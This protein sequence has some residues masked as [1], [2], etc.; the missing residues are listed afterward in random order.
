MVAKIDT[1]ID[2]ADEIEVDIDVVNE[3]EVEKRLDAEKIIKSTLKDEG[4]AAG[5]EPLVKAVKKLGIDKDQH[6]T[7]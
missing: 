3:E 4:G 2:N 7:Y 5:L 1:M 6:Q